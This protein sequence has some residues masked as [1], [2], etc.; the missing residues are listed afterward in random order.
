MSAPALA[1]WLA[2]QL[3]A[4]ETYPDGNA[5]FNAITNRTGIVFVKGF[6]GITDPGRRW[7][8]IDVW[9]GKNFAKGADERWITSSPK[10]VWFWP[11][12]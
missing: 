4:P 7:N 1:E 12:K 5:A 3:G 6:V 9:D 10:Q 8:H 11:I 2:T